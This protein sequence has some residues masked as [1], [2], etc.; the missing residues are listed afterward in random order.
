MLTDVTRTAGLTEYWEFCEATAV[1]VPHLNFFQAW[2][3]ARATV[4]PQDAF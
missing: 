4:G 3:R 2:Q 1:S